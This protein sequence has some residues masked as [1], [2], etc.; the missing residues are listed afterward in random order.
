MSATEIQASG[1]KLQDTFT[2]EILRLSIPES[3]PELYDRKL[4]P[5]TVFQD[6]FLK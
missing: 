4:V 2:G 3:L 1:K 5:N 6:V